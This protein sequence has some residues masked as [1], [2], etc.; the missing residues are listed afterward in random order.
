MSG[1]LIIAERAKP[2]GRK[3]EVLPALVT[4]AGGPAVQAWADCFEG[5]IPNKHTRRNYK[6]YVRHFLD[7]CEVEELELARIMAGDVG[8]YLEGLTGGP[9]KK[10]I[11]LSALR[12][13]FRLLV[14]RH[15][16]LIN[17]A[18]EAETDRY[19]VVEGKTTEITDAQFRELLAT[20]DPTT[21]VGLRDL[22]IIK[23]LAYTGARVGAVAGLE[24][25]HYYEA[26]GTW[27]LHFDDKGGKSREIPV[28]HDL[29]VLYEEYLEKTG[30]KQERR[31]RDP[32][33]G[34]WESIYLFRTAAGRTGQLTKTPMTGNDIYKMMRRRAARAGI[35]TGISPHSFRVAIATDL[36]EQGVPTDEIQML[37]GH[38]DVRTTNLYKRNR[39]GVT[40]NLV[41]RIRLGR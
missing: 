29:Q 13:F 32:K 24:R 31:R 1:E 25:P 9:N 22:V 36:H 16:C 38:S 35:G 5:K 6:R 18:A 20:I 12:K 3:A 34:E 37:L 41:E 21:I 30:I 14:Q 28:A 19:N 4:R 17:P 40:R 11:A 2:P 15:I 39:R 26:P 23:T 10:K 8:R 27:M 33:T 7:W